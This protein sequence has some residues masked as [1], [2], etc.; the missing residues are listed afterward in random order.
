[1][2][3]PLA[4]LHKLF[5]CSSKHPNIQ[6]MKNMNFYIWNILSSSFLCFNV[7]QIII[8][9]KFIRYLSKTFQNIEFYIRNFQRQGL[10]TLVFCPLVPPD[11]PIYS[12]PLL[13]AEQF[14]K[15]PPLGLSTTALM[16][17]IYSV[18]VR[19]QVNQKNSII[20]GRKYKSRELLKAI[21]SCHQN[22]Q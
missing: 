20:E 15:L 5:L 9:R 2:I 6:P 10:I 12:P 7:L 19:G 17:A 16:C 14:P 4:F 22:K 11:K 13:Q 8:E 18:L 1:M 21:L 3:L